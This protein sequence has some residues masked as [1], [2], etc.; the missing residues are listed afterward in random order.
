MDR[1]E[2]AL[3]SD[4]RRRYS[5]GCPVPGGFLGALWQVEFA[6][7]VEAAPSGNQRIF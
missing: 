2:Q 3:R 1:C 6:S 4:P 5:A 7:H